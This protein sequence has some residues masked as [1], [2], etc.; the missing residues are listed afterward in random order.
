MAETTHDTLIAWLQE[1]HAFA[2]HGETMLGGRAEA[3][4]SDY[5]VLSNRLNEHVAETRQHRR[6]IAQLLDD[7]GA[8]TSTAKDIG[9]KLSALGHSWGTQLS[10][11]TPVQAV[12]ASI[13]FEHFEI[14]NYRALIAVADIAEAGQVK[15][16]LESLVADDVAMSQWLDDTL[17]DITRRYVGA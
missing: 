9:G 6:E 4:S 16:T 5:P 1:A 8:D 15:A 14:A 10:G 13:A 2:Q 11:E 12:A 7:L 17:I 3:L